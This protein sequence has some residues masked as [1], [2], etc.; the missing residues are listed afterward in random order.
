MNSYAET[1]VAEKELHHWE[2]RLDRASKPPKEAIVADRAHSRGR[3][4]ATRRLL[5]AR[6][7]LHRLEKLSQLEV[8]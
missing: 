2:E 1:Q 4:N 8:A 5:L 6:D 7:E 3:A